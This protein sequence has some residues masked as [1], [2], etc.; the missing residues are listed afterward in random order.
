M[1]DTP[2]TMQYSL[3]MFRCGA[4]VT[5]KQRR[6]IYANNYFLDEL[7]WPLDELIGKAIDEIFNR[8]SKIFCESYLMPLLMHN[9]KYEEIQLS[10]LD[11][12][13]VKIPVIVNAHMDSNET[14]YWS[15]FNATNR[16]KLYQELVDARTKLEAQAEVLESL[17]STDDL[18]GLMNKREMTIRAPLLLE[19]SQRFKHSISVLMID[20]DFFKKINDN[21]GHLEGD[22]V[23]KEFGRCL[24]EF[25]RQ[26]DLISRFGGEEFLLMLPDTNSE[27]ANVC[28]KRVHDLVTKIRV[29]N[30]PITVSIGICVTDGTQAY[31]T[32]CLRA[33]QALY[34]AKNSGRNRTVFFK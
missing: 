1:H 30:G 26:S 23:L 32:I 7:K 28:A 6:I 24:T 3:D 9:K 5:D 29:A 27:G 11:G 16:S 2:K 20:I 15:I 8:P 33:D 19:Q 17:S 13:G 31:E 25:G 4:L 21:H 34:Q 22:R 12:K 14:I 18:T 10:L